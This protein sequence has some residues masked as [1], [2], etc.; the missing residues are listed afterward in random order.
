[1]EN[2]VIHLPSK[3]SWPTE[4]NTYSLVNHQIQITNKEVII[5]AEIKTRDNPVAEDTNNEGVATKMGEDPAEENSYSSLVI[6]SITNSSRTPHNSNSKV[7]NNSH[8]M[9]MSQTRKSD[10]SGQSDSN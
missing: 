8:P 1:M 7:N 9:A 10:C 4:K 3:I 6:M 5:L 2:Q